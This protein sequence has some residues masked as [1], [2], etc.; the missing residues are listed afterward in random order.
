LITRNA[1]AGTIAVGAA[2]ALAMA[3]VPASASTAPASA[4]QTAVSAATRTQT[5]G[6]CSASGDHAACALNVQA[7]RPVIMHAHI[8]ATPARVIKG[9]FS[10]QCSNRN[11]EGAGEVGVF[12]SRGPIR[13]RLR[14]GIANPVSCSLSLHGHLPG[15]GKLHVSV[16]AT[17]KR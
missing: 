3:A 8:T 1:I 10:F 7:N 12:D 4:A 16:T 17:Y 14:P 13:L 6:S 15:S 2:A 9:R 5:I 11:H